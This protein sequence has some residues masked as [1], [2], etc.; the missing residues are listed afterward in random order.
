M[1]SRL[2]PLLLLNAVDYPQCEVSGNDRSSATSIDNNL[3]LKPA[4]KRRGSMVAD[5]ILRF[6]RL[7]N[8]FNGLRTTLQ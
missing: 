1:A 8:R 6:E 2:G 7:Q 3:R 4:A 5:S